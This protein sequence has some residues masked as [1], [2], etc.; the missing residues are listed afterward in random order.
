[1]NASNVVTLL[2]TTFNATGQ[3]IAYPSGGTPEVTAILVEMAPGESTGWHQHP[4]PL[5][6]YILSGELTVYQA[7]GQKRVVPAGQVSLES[8]DH[9]HQGI[10]EGLVPVKMI[11]F[12][13]G[14]KD[15]PMTIPSDFKP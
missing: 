13:V 7:D 9:V 15:V 5:L 6:G 8:V 14:L 1:M 2:Q 3:A 11:V 4:I 10:N 12:A